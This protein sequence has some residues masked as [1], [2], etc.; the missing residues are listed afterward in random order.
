[1][2]SKLFFAAALTG[3]AFALGAGHPFRID[4]RNIKCM[5]SAPSPSAVT[6]NGIKTGK[7]G[8]NGLSVE[9]TK[10]LESGA[11]QENSFTFTPEKDGTFELWLRGPYRKQP[12]K[13]RPDKLWVFYD[14]LKVTGAEMK[15]SDF[16]LADAK[17]PDLPQGWKSA[18][19]GMT[20]VR[21]E[22]SGAYA[23]K[24]HHDG[25]FSQTL[26]VRAG[27]PVTVS[28]LAGG[29]EAETEH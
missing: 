13:Q 27:V 9:G 28:F 15:N 4:L 7:L 29:G 22:A 18:G 25:L 23:V 19:K 2:N 20:R 1:M 6:G 16:K 8:G 17:K 21:N 5:E 11:W 26:S 3:I 24:V 12:D 10:A 14:Q